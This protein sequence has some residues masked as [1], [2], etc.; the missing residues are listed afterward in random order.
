MTDR[1]LTYQRGGFRRY[2]HEELN[3]M[4][5]L[6][7]MHHLEAAEGWLDRKMYADCFDELEGIDY[8][9]RGDGRELALRWKLY[10]R[11]GQY[12]PAANLALGIQ[13][14]F[15]NEPAG[16]VWRAVSLTALGCT[17]EAYDDLEAVAGKFDGLG[18]VPYVLAILA[19]QLQRMELARDWL[20]KAFAT[21]DG[22]QLKLLALEEKELDAFWRKIGDI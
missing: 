2:S 19:A 20:V 9:N 7:D 18:M 10:N 21:P 11:S 16:Y 12:V 14:R 1:L 8:N 15:P 13:R 5:S 22:Q 6:A 3:L 4:L 17:Q